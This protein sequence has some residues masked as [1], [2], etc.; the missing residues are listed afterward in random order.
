[1]PEHSATFFSTPQNWVRKYCLM[2]FHIVFCGELSALENWI[3]D[4]LFFILFYVIWRVLILLTSDWFVDRFFYFFL[5]CFLSSFLV[6]CLSV[7][8]S[9]FL[10]P[11]PLFLSLSLS[12]FL[13]HPFSFSH[14]SC[15]SPSHSHTPLL[16]CW[17][18][19]FLIYIFF[20]LLIYSLSRLA[21]VHCCTVLHRY[22]HTFTPIGPWTGP[23]VSVSS[24]C[25]TYSV[26]RAV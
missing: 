19:Y 14:S 1:M 16:I 26:P 18:S 6:V 20:Y 7:C 25:C 10:V 4:L 21:C 13:F 24:T 3:Y 22:T 12:I 2:I 17:F 8:L 15:S 5:A 9:V 23:S 11:P